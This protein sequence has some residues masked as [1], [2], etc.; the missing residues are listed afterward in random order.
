MPRLSLALLSFLGTAAAQTKSNI[1]V[2][3]VRPRTAS[4][5]IWLAART[6]LFRAVFKPCGARCHKSGGARRD[7]TLLNIYRTALLRAQYKL[8]SPVADIQ[9]VGSDKKTVTAA[10][11]P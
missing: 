3:E 10:A 5:A 9:W 1:T 6:A 4:L 2:Y 7:A 8:D 11:G